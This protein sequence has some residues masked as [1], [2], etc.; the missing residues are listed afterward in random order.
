MNVGETLG[1]VLRQTTRLPIGKGP[2]QLRILAPIAIEQRLPLAVR[3]AAPF[4]A[5][6]P[7]LGCLGRHHELLLFRPSQDRLGLRDLFGAE[8][9]TMGRG[10]VSLGRCGIG[11]VGPE[12]DDRGPVGFGRRGVQR[13][14]DGFE[15]VAVSH[16]L[17]LPAVAFE[18]SP[19]V[20]A[21]G[22]PGR[23]VDR[24]AIVVVDQLETAQPQMP[25]ERRRFAGDAFHQI[26]VAHQ[27]PDP[28]F[29]QLETG[30]VEVI[31]QEP[32]GDRHA[33]RVPYTL[34]ER[35]RRSLDAGACVPA[36]DAPA[37]GSR[38]DG[39]GGCRRG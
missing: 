23:S 14:R 6:L 25:R 22:E 34:A 28:V 11:D 36:P 5:A 10:G 19:H 9:S 2:G 17:H 3:L 24:D 13:A 18:P 27:R 31:R 39:T 4:Q 38:I 26:A 29:H 1:P 30:P 21:E 16:V 35:S 37:S 8:R 15:V 32:L 20:L 33:H 12:D 7:P